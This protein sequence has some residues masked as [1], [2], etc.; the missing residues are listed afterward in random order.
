MEEPLDDKSFEEYLKGRLENLEADPADDAW[1]NIFGEISQDEAAPVEKKSRFGNRLWLL[2]AFILWIIPHSTH[3]LPVNNAGQNKAHKQVWTKSPE[4]N[5]KNPVQKPNELQHYTS[6]TNTRAQIVNIDKNNLPDKQIKVSQKTKL[7]VTPKP[8][9]KKLVAKRKRVNKGQFI[10]EPKLAMLPPRKK[11]GKK[12]GKLQNNKIVARKP[13]TKT[14][15]VFVINKNAV[16]QKTNDKKVNSGKKKSHPVVLPLEA[17]TNAGFEF[18]PRQ[19]VI[20]EVKAP[21]KKKSYRNLLLRAYLSPTYN[22]HRLITN[23]ED[24][25]IIQSIEKNGLLSGNNLGFSGGFMLESNLSRRW[26]VLWGIS[27]TQLN[28]KINYS[29]TNATPDS[30]M[31]DFV[32]ADQVRV[33]PVYNEVSKSY[34]YQYQDIG[35]Q[36][37]ANYT[38]LSKRWKHKVYAG[39]AANRVTKTITQTDEKIIHENTSGIQTL[40]N[41]GYDMQMPLS[42]RLAF[43][44]KPTFNYYLKTIDQANKAYQVKPYFTSLR[45][46]LI[47][48]LK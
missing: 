15:T 48:R 17:Q 4:R 1:D 7:V 42:S 37:G 9:N 27:Y 44:L 39:F 12:Q 18:R 2:T 45:L 34:R 26:S 29:F 5:H 43:Y 32:T 33:T 38:L 47:W 25:V 3:H 24:N 19:V 41:V 46:G 10:A 35:V 22:Y 16:T 31:V 30:L 14:T 6:G 8:T 36:L 20:K 13:V 28:N 40:I 23:K 11:V 21:K